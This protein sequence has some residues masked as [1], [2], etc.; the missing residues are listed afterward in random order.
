MPN[1]QPS[2]TDLPAEELTSNTLS[3]A[4]NDSSEEKDL[5][6][7]ALPSSQLV[8]NEGTL[9]DGSHECHGQRS[10]YQTS[11]VHSH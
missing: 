6:L 10:C 5:E 9:S 1:M 3:Q 8:N 4:E 11:S 2:G 7:N